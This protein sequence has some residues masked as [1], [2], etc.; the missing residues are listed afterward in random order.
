MVT[1]GGEVIEWGLRTTID[2]EV[3]EQTDSSSGPSSRISSPHL[4]QGFPSTV[5]VSQVACGQGFSVTLT[6]CGKVFVFGRWEGCGLGRVH[7]GSRCNRPTQITKFYH[8]AGIATPTI[9]TVSACDDQAG[10]VD[11]DGWVWTWGV[12]T[13]RD[14]DPGWRPRR[15]EGLSLCSQLSLSGSH[16]L[17]VGRFGELYAWGS[18]TRGELG[19]G[20]LVD[21]YSPIRVEISSRCTAAAAGPGFSLAVDVRGRLFG[22][23]LRNRTL[24]SGRADSGPLEGVAAFTV[25]AAGGAVIPEFRNLEISALRPAV[26]LDGWKIDK[27]AAGGFGVVAICNEGVAFYWANEGAS[28][29]PRILP[30]LPLQVVDAIAI[31]PL[32]AVALSSTFHPALYSLAK[33]LPGRMDFGNVGL[34]AEGAAKVWV[35]EELLKSR[36]DPEVW[37]VVFEPQLQGSDTVESVSLLDVLAEVRGQDPD[38]QAS[39][40]PADHHDNP[41]AY[42]I[43]SSCI[44]RNMPLSRVI[45]L[46]HFLYTDTLP[47]HISENDLVELGI[48]A[49]CLQLDRLRHLSGARL[50]AQHLD[51]AEAEGLGLR[52]WLLE[53]REKRRSGEGLQS[54]SFVHS[55]LLHSGS[56]PNLIS[57]LS[58]TV[59]DHILHAC[60][61][62]HYTGELPQIQ[63]FSASDVD[64]LLR[65]AQAFQS[66]TL[67]AAAEDLSI[68][69]IDEASWLTIL[70][71]ALSQPLWSCPALK[72]AC[73]CFAI[74]PVRLH[75]LELL[76][77]AG[78]MEPTD[79]ATWAFE[80]ASARLEG[81]RGKWPKVHADVAE[82]LTKDL[83]GAVKAQRLVER[84]IADLRDEESG[85]SVVDKK[86]TSGLGKEFD[87]QPSVFSV[88]RDLA[89]ALAAILAVAVLA[90]LTP[91]LVQLQDRLPP[92]F[93]AFLVGTGGMILMICVNIA[94]VGLLVTSVGKS[95]TRD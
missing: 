12:S 51:P 23:G 63:S 7:P 10:C 66:Q 17:A 76:S 50:L 45:A 28:H 92:H 5:I 16:A 1:A 75:A 48:I 35:Q 72:S 80:A 42:C 53:L 59:F 90:K 2:C 67:I 68:S 29:A 19:T 26:V 61:D 77:H 62:F 15:V 32:H 14:D 9:G 65:A 78:H 60:I 74:D 40:D 30:N 33:S 52:D 54:D 84:F 18:N 83:L 27:I 55:F 95:L 36:L 81:L 37:R 88:S 46:I 91:W 73:L 82:S 94:I 6:A 4:I 8:A 49:V 43:P 87:G 44:F 93:R 38:E 86:K 70:S 71:A 22:W 58:A 69:L 89:I 31:G 21:R 3:D 56:K 79:A 34:V 24:F 47:S 20:D 13:Q 39:N 41:T 64:P 25:L 11:V 85:K 57:Q